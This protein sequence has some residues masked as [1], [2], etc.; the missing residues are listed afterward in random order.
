MHG[1]FWN[2]GHGPF[3]GGGFFMVIFWICIIFLLISILKGVFKGG[4]PQESALDIL[5]KRY[6]AGEF[7]L[8]EFHQMK[9][10]IL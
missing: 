1:Y 9:K 2:W 6:S 4:K 7:T 10:E 8:D 3:W 5:K